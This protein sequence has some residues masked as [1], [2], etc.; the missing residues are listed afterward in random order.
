MKWL[1]GSLKENAWTAM[2]SGYM[3]VRDFGKA[4]LLFEEMPNRDLPSWN[5]VIAGCTQNGLFS[6]AISLLRKMV[7]GEKGRRN[8]PNQVTVVCS[9]S[10]CGHTGK[11]QL[12]KSIHGY[13]YRNGIGN[14]FLVANV[15]IEMY[16]S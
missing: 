2:L 7:M 6:E 14:D 16:G 1:R 3:R 15:L 10:A 8:R 9:L 5:A 13:V 11:F 12:G 4:L